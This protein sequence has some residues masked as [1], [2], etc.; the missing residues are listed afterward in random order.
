MNS[1]SSNSEPI[2]PDHKSAS[3]S[4]PLQ[5]P[6]SWPSEEFRK[7]YGLKRIVDILLSSIGLILLMP[8]FLVVAILIKV[9]SPG[10][11]LFR[12]QRLSI[13]ERPFTLI[14]FR[15]MIHQAEAKTGPTWV[16]EQD[17][18]ITRLG[19][20][21]RKTHLDEM[22]QL[23]NVL[24][25]EMSLIGPRPERPVFVKQFREQ[26]IGN[27]SCRHFFRPGITGYAQMLNP[28]PTIEQIQDKTEADLWY[29]T[30]WSIKLELWLIRQTFFYFFKSLFKLVKK[31]RLHSD[32]QEKH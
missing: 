6:L 22:P 30:H 24:I 21:L 10:P 2:Q 27:Y 18:R 29:V 32:S 4:L 25:G 28:N 5:Y 14:K 9:C 16:Q 7:F 1:S 19:H 23:W 17:S 11:V 31:S 13:H 3:V 15:T 8:V 12:Q 26:K 20:L